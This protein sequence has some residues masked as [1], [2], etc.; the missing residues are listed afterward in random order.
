[1]KTIHFIRHAESQAN[2]GQATFDN[3]TIALT[4]KGKQQAEALVSKIGE[5]PD[6]IIC[7]KFMRTQQTAAPLSNKFPQTPVKILP[8]HEFTYLSPATCAGTTVYRR[9][10]WACDYWDA[11]SPIFTHGEGAESFI[12]FTERIDQSLQCLEMC[13]Y[14]NIAVFTHGHV[15]RAIWQQ[16]SGHQFS[17][18]EERMHHFYHHMS[19]LPV[20]NACIFKATFENNQW[21]I[22]DPQP[23]LI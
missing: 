4:E 12:Q 20:P 6:L 10:T 22:I 7:S 21:Q 11:C 17:S 1:M 13:E 15:L 23:L 16:L 3:K 5:K 9:Q 8:L 14:N 2:A 18:D 19:L